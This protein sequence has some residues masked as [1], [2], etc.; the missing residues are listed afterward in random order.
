MKDSKVKYI[1]FSGSYLPKN[2]LALSI[3]LKR[4]TENENAIA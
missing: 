2:D 3:I 1:H 4:K